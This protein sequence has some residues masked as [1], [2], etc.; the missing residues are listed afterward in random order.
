MFWG[1]FSELGRGPLVAIEG[2][3]KSKQYKQVLRQYFLPEANYLKENGHQVKLMHDNAPCHVSKEI[4][5][6][7]ADTGVEFL[8]WPAYSPDLNPIK[9]VWAWIKYKLYTEFD[10]C[11]SK[12]ELIDHV[13][14][15]WGTL[16]VEMCKRY[17]GNYSKRLIECRNKNG[18]NTKY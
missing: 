13:F 1:C 3:M 7:L 10:S 5:S 15:L 4:T 12:Q 9:N 17:C 6:F 11:T 2:N 16:D 18:L 8:E 14:H